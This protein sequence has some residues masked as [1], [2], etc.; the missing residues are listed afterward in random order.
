MAGRWSWGCGGCERRVAGGSRAVERQQKVTLRRIAL[1]FSTL[2][3][4]TT[5]C[6]LHDRRRQV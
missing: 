3:A 1:F 2:S 6:R 4:M 5:R